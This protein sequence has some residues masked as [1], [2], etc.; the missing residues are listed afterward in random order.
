MKKL[1]ME[2]REKEQDQEKGLVMAE[3]NLKKPMHITFINKSAL[4]CLQYKLQEALELSINSLMP[5]FIA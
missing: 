1:A 5:L 4:T 3:I 2:H